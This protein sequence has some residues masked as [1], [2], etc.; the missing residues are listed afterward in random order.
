M[1]ITE[2]GLSDYVLELYSDNPIVNPKAVLWGSKK[3]TTD[4]SGKAS[5]SFSVVLPK[6]VETL[7][8][9]RRDS[10]NRR[11]VKLANVTS[12]GVTASFGLNPTTSRAKTRSLIDGDIQTMDCP[13]T[14]EEINSFVSTAFNINSGKVPNMYWLE[15]EVDLSSNTMGGIG[16]KSET[17]SA[18][19]TGELTVGQSALNLSNI[20]D[21]NT[22]GNTDNY[23]FVN[24]GRRVKLIVGEGGVLK[25]N[26]AADILGR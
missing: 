13:Y 5:A 21:R 9:V 15:G 24:S 7:Y 23:S 26:G 10:H 6:V 4:A 20:W 16:I 14:K 22:S 1:D 17:Y 25:F 11:L 19:L 2:D 8:A 18:I 12:N 3:V